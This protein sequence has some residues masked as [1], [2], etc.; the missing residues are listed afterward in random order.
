MYQQYLWEKGYQ[1][2][3][4]SDINDLS[5]D[6]VLEDIDTVIKILKT[7][8]L[9]VIVVNRIRPQIGIPAVKIVIPGTQRVDWAS[10]FKIDLLASGS[11]RVLC[12][13]KKQRLRRNISRIEE[14]DISQ[15]TF[16]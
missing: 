3:S 10:L 14:L 6:D 9:D 12:V 5:K 13:P 4:L 8:N 11:D 2:I 1:T 16:Q 15:I 7:Q